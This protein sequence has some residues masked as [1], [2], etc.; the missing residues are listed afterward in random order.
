LKFLLRWK[1]RELSSISDSNAVIFESKI[2]ENHDLKCW[3]HKQLISFGRLVSEDSLLATEFEFS[4]FFQMYSKEYLRYL[5]NIKKDLFSSINQKSIRYL[6]ISFVAFFG[7]IQY[8]DRIISPKHK[9]NDRHIPESYFE[10]SR[11]NPCFVD[12]VLDWSGL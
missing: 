6:T 1:Q 11:N 5:I 8:F 10:G 2:R 12:W 9:V 4:L 7:V 3:S